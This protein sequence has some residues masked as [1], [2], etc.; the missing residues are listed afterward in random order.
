MQSLN[1]SYNQTVSRAYIIRVK[2]HAKSEEKAQRCADSCDL[3]GM[4]WAYWDAYDGI[5]NPIK[6][7]LHHGG[8]PAMVKV[9]DHYLTR[10][11]V[12]CA[13]SHISLWQKCVL[14]DQPLVVLEHDACLLYTSDAADE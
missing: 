14:D 13:L 9:T 3:A 10:G 7:P 6:P 5:Q 12:A 1:Y 4:P 2:G 8:V 11:E